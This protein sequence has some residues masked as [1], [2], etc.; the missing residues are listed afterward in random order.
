MVSNLDFSDVVGC[1]SCFQ[2]PSSGRFWKATITTTK[3]TPNQQGQQLKRV[4]FKLLWLFNIVLSNLSFSYWYS[5]TAAELLT[6]PMEPRGIVKAFPKRKKVRDDLGKSVPPKISKEEGREIPEGKPCMPVT[7]N[8]V[9]PP[10]LVHW[11]CSSAKGCVF[12]RVYGQLALLCPPGTLQ[13]LPVTVCA[14]PSCMRSV[15]WLVWDTFSCH[16]ASAPVFSSAEWL[17]PVTAYVLQAGIGQARAEI[18]HKQIVQN[19]G[20]VHNQLSSEVTHIIVAEDMDCNRALRL[21]KLTKLPPGLQL[22]KASWLSACIRDQK[23]LSTA[24]YG[25]FIPCRYA[26]AMLLFLRAVLLS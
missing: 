1:K 22:V 13:G 10:H 24:G 21:L 26:N 16:W 5:A 7:W 11:R 4:N 18:F 25:V 8:T 9:L 17:K 20:V 14:I 6:R 12:C 23:L 19:G 2:V 3:E 15:A